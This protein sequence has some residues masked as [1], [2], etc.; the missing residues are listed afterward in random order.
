MY[1]QTYMEIHRNWKDVYL[2]YMIGSYLQRYLAN[3]YLLG[4][5]LALKLL[6]DDVWCYL[7][8]MLHRPT[9]M[10]MPL[11]CLVFYDLG[12]FINTCM[13]LIRCDVLSLMLSY[14]CPTWMLLV[15]TDPKELPLERCVYLVMWCVPK[16]YLLILAL[17]LHA[18][19]GDVT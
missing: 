9:L 6:I 3:M 14:G 17:C 8:M 15:D 1:L 18:T 5:G 12:P 7:Q 10:M 4:V 13:D 2:S 11:C 19:T 16:T